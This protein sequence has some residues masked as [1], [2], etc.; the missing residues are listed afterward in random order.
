MLIADVCLC[1]D[2]V[3]ARYPL[4]PPSPRQNT[5][6]Q[7]KSQL[8]PHLANALL[9]AASRALTTRPPWEASVPL[10]AL[11]LS[12]G[13]LLHAQ[14][15]AQSQALDATS[16]VPVVLFSLPDNLPQVLATLLTEGLPSLPFRHCVM[17]WRALAALGMSCPAPPL[18]FNLNQNQNQIRK[19]QN[20][21]ASPPPHLDTTT[22]VGNQSPLHMTIPYHTIP[23]HTIPYHTVP[24]YASLF[25]LCYPLIEFCVIFC[26]FCLLLLWPM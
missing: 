23:Y 25:A 10:L 7:K 9:M 13:M 21:A 18:N 17:A 16:S 14:S 15:Q 8:Q 3:S 1:C 2:G 19:H 20:Q 24:Y 4:P 5:N 11:H 22:L 26:I 6:K 12:T